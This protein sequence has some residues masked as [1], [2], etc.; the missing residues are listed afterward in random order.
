MAAKLTVLAAC[1]HPDDIEY[2][3]AGALGLIWEPTG[4]RFG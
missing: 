2:Y 4:R 1:A 3:C